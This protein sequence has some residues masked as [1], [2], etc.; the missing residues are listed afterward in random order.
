MT[1]TAATKDPTGAPVTGDAVDLPAD[2]GY[3]LVLFNGEQGGSVFFNRRMIG[4]VGK[5]L[6][7]SCKEAKWMRIGKMP[8]PRWLSKGT[9]VR[10]KCQ[11]LTKK[12]AS[13]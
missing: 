10:I 1:P 9:T 8:G 6:R 11:G 7:V 4:P 5:R 13:P 12:F 2:M 3:L